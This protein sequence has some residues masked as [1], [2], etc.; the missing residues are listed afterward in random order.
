TGPSPGPGSPSLSA[1]RKAEI[2]NSIDYPG[3]REP[4]TAHGEVDPI[5]EAAM[6]RSVPDAK[7]VFG[8]AVE[9]PD[10]ADPAAVL[11]EACAGAPEVRAEVQG[12]LDALRGAGSFMRSP[13]APAPNT[14]DYEPPISEGEGTVIGPYTLRE[15][16]GEGGFGLVFVAEQTHPVRRK[17]ALKVIKPG[18][19]TRA[20]VAP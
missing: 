7:S 4:R 16:I 5:S 11:D 13:A 12:L 15:Q 10:G 6:S 3:S 2:R 14:E 8:R 20:V 19:D 17:V 9:I 18:M 1:G